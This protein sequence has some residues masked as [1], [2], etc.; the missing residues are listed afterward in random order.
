MTADLPDLSSYDGVLFDLDGVL[1]PT[2]EVHKHAW[3]KIFTDLF[4]AWGIS[5]EYTDDD[6]YRYLD[7][8]QRYDGVASLLRSRDV[9]IP[10]GD[11][12]DP[13]SADTVYGVGNRKNEV[14]AAVLREDG[15]APYPGSLA[16]L[17]RLRAAGTPL[18]VV[19]SSKNA[20]EVLA[21]AGI[22]DFFRIVM[23]GVVAAREGLRSKPEPD[24]FAEGARMLG[25]DPAR[26]AA[27]EDAHSGVQSA[28]AAGFGLVVGVDRGAGAQALLDHG[29]DLV[30]DDLAAF[31]S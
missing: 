1:T 26:S 20:E 2:A 28:S 29:A 10:W 17:E 5:P 23:D 21:A 13:P 30:V 18:G 6:Y 12:S 25:V 27:V 16:L 19:S 4:S 24:M 22:R 3:R 11:P 7:G 14:F 9:E 15:I 8:K 31:V